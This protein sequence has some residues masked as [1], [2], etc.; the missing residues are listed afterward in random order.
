VFY[1][2]T[3]KEHCQRRGFSAANLGPAES[4]NQKQGRQ[5]LIFNKGFLYRLGVGIKDS[6]ER[7][8]CVPVLCI[9]CTPVISLGIAIR[10]LVLNWNPV[11]GR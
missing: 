6:G 11:I 7:L 1:A 5:I 10:D 4:R 8:A 2:V 3:Q 9:F